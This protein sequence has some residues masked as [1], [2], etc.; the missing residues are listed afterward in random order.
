MDLEPITEEDLDDL[1]EA[2][3]P[4][5][6]CMVCFNP[7]KSWSNDLFLYTCTCIYRVHPECF[8][9][10]RVK[11][12]TNRVCLICRDE[13]DTFGYVEEEEDVPIVDPSGLGLAA[14]VVAQ[15]NPGLDAEIDTAANQC[16]IIEKIIRFIIIA[17]MFFCFIL[18]INI[19]LTIAR[20]LYQGT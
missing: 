9:E 1:R 5:G 17:S 7:C 10:W 4:S 18:T 3:D 14:R 11:T 19:L 8:R 6:N 13:F 20:S 15:F 2:I 12:K 16:C